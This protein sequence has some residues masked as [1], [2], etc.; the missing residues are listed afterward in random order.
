MTHRTLIKNTVRAVVLQPDADA[1]TV[2]DA[3]L[4]ADLPE[5]ER[6]ALRALILDELRRLHEGVLAR[7][8][9]RPSQL[10]AWQS[11]QGML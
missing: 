5:P 8:G 6:Q 1:Q 2:L 3:A 10:K 11:A 9:L 7:Y 4:P